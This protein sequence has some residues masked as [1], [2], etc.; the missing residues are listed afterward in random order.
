MPLQVKRVYASPHHEDG[1]RILVDRLWPRGL[2]KEAAAIDEWV[3]ECAPSDELRKW[4][5]HDRAKW[6]E[7][8]R[9][10]SAE[11]RSKEELL[12]PIRSMANEKRVTLLFAASDTEC[13]N[14]VALME[15]LDETTSS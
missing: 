8:K 1:L 4:F 5:A 6:N 15:Y 13:N 9:R 3:R 7:F 12:A 10:Y 2:A 11:L 14:A